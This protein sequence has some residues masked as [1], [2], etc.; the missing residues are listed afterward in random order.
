MR[1]V[2][3]SLLLSITSVAAAELDHLQIDT[4][5]VRQQAEAEYCEFNHPDTLSS[6]TSFD[7][8]EFV[9]SSEEEAPVD[10]IV[11]RIENKVE[12][13]FDSL[14]LSCSDPDIHSYLVFQHM[15]LLLKISRIDNT[16]SSRSHL[17][18][19]EN[20]LAKASDFIHLLYNIRT[21][22]QHFTLKLERSELGK[23]LFR[24]FKSGIDERVEFHFNRILKRTSLLSQPFIKKDFFELIDNL[25]RELSPPPKKGGVLNLQAN[26]EQETISKYWAYFCEFCLDYLKPHQKKIFM[27]LARVF[28]KYKEVSKQLYLNICEKFPDVFSSLPSTVDTV[29]HPLFI[30]ALLKK[31]YENDTGK[32]DD[33]LHQIIQRALLERQLFNDA[34]AIEDESPE[35]VSAHAGETMVT[36]YQDSFKD[37]KTDSTNA[38]S[39]PIIMAKLG[40]MIQHLRGAEFY[41]SEANRQEPDPG[42]IWGS[43]LCI[44]P[45]VV[46]NIRLIFWNRTG[47]QD[48][49]IQSSNQHQ[50]Y[51][52]FLSGLWGNPTSAEYLQ[53]SQ[54]FNNSLGIIH[55]LM[56]VRSK[57]YPPYA[58]TG[59]QTR[60]ENLET[61]LVANRFVRI[62]DSVSGNPDMH[63]WYHSTLPLVV[64]IKRNGE[65][66][67]EFITLPR[68]PSF[69]PKE[70]QQFETTVC[71]KTA[72][73]NI[74]KVAEI[75]FGNTVGKFIFFV[76]VGANSQI[77]VGTQPYTFWNARFTSTDQ[78]NQ[79]I[80]LNDAHPH[81]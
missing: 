29:S 37:F 71:D 75:D 77:Y 25:S 41:F 66:T 69:S 36:R 68:N 39:R 43:Y 74:A 7:W 23:R 6:N 33:T 47:I 64:R 27:E 1:K 35:H 31:R 22:L 18:K 54:L 46:Q 28:S 38:Q 53:V 63:Y 8:D 72:R 48:A 81:W 60:P 14:K 11:K 76:P 79:L 49:L 70:K 3:I 21:N 26:N 17:T 61:T 51:S 67:I 19:F 62:S 12:E 50:T 20:D 24:S 42:Y 52:S 56:S 73:V 55:S 15:L 34:I 5:S 13:I 40:E 16:E 44:I 57:G 80:A 58:R 65:Y 4:N 2:G 45:Q 32:V 59:T 10:Q 78:N 9:S 30:A